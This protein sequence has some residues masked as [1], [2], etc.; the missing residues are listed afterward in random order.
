MPEFKSLPRTLRVISLIGALLLF[1]S[2]LAYRIEL[3][4]PATPDINNTFTTLTKPAPT[5]IGS[6]DV[7]GHVVNQQEADQL[8][9]EGGQERLSPQNGAVA[10]TEELL[11]LGRRT[12][13][14]ET[15]GNQVFQTDVVGALQ[16]PINP[17]TMTKASAAL[18]V[19][20][21]PTCKFQW[22]GMSPLGDGPS[23][24]VPYSIPAWTC[25]HAHSSL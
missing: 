14:G 9:Q 21:L 10:I 2:F 20:R 1:F 11:N 15:F 16:G 25:Q 7:L 3:V 24:K 19:N 22:I 12:F 8:Q 23:R 18:G 4:F 13:Y 17:V 6:Y 5:A